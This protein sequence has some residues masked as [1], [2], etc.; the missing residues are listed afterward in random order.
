MT[1]TNKILVREL[2]RQKFRLEEVRD[3]IWWRE[4]GETGYKPFTENDYER[5]LAEFRAAGRE[6]LLGI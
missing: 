4:R 3:A 5:V 2:R 1:A 6:G